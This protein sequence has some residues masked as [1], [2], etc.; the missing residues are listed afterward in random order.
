MVTAL[1]RLQEGRLALHRRWK[2]A[3]LGNQQLASRNRIKIAAILFELR[4]LG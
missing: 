4:K 1:R 3:F 2:D